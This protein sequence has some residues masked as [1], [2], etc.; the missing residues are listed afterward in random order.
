MLSL[1]YKKLTEDKSFAQSPNWRLQKKLIKTFLWKILTY[2]TNKKKKK[3]TNLSIG[4]N[5]E[6][7]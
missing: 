3:K 1:K 7:I 6:E 5:I 2:M 4:E